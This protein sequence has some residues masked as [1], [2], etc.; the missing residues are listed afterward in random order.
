MCSLNKKL[1]SLLLN[2]FFLV[3]V[4]LIY[5]QILNVSMCNLGFIFIWLVSIEVNQNKFVLWEVILK[6]MKEGI[7]LIKIEKRWG[8]LYLEY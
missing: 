8:F 5:F 4:L 2:Y 7:L 6:K 1:I 3:L